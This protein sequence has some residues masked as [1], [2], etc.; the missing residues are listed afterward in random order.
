MKKSGAGY[1]IQ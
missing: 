1:L